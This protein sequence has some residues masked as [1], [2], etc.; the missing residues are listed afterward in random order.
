MNKKKIPEFINDYDLEGF[1]KIFPNIKSN[2][3]LLLSKL[4][5]DDISKKTPPYYFK[6]DDEI[7]KILNKIINQ[8]EDEYLVSFKEYF[9]SD[10][11]PAYMCLRRNTHYKKLDLESELFNDNF[12][13]DAYLF[14]HFKVF[15]NLSDVSE[16][17]GPMKIVSKK[18]AKDFLKYINYKDRKNYSDDDEN[19]SFSNT[20]R[21]ADCLFFDPTNCFHKAGMPEENQKRDYLIITYVCVPKSKKLI[22]ELIKTDIYKYENNKLLSLSKPTH[23]LQTLKLL[24]DFYKK[25]LN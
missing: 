19:F 12:H 20:G 4:E 24:L 22:D 23:F 11:L 5:I 2:I 3:N 8:I 6:I 1:V 9:N 18:K 15:I 13:N 14:T 21:V 17:D 7:K 25:K 10:I 16:K